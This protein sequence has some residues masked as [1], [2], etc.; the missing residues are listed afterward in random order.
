MPQIHSTVARRRVIGTI[1]GVVGM[2]PTA[3]VWFLVA[4]YFVWPRVLSSIFD[5]FIPVGVD[6]PDNWA[7]GATRMVWFFLWCCSVGFAFFS[8][9]LWLRRRAA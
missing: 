1:L 8:L 2:L 6:A 7:V 5:L 3:A 9:G 4:S